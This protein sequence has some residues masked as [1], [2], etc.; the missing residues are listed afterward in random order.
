[1]P[2]EIF[3][4][5]ALA[6]EWSGDYDVQEVP[7]DEKPLYQVGIFILLLATVVLG[8]I[9]FLNWSNG[10]FYVDRAE[11]NLGKYERVAAARG[12]IT[13]RYGTV[14]AENKAVFSGYL[15][16]REFLRNEDIQNPT[17]KGMREVLGIS[18][19]DAWNLIRSKNLEKSIEPLIL[20]VDLSQRE[21][22]ALKE[23]DL[24]T[25]LV[26]E[27]FR[28]DYPDGRMFS[29]VLGYIGLPT[30]KDLE[31][32]PELSGEDFI[33]KAGVEAYYEDDLR[34]I[35]GLK[36]KLRDARGQELDE[37]ERSAPESGKTLQ[38]T[39]DADLQRYFYDR[40]S[41]AL[42]ALDRTGGIGMAMNPKTGEVL[43][44][45]NFPVYDNNIFT[46]SGFGEERLSLLRDTTRPLFDRA[47]SGVYSPGSTIKPLVGVAALAERIIEPERTIFSPGYLDIP[48]P[49]Q[50]DKPTRFVDWRFQGEVDLGAALAQSSNVY[51]YEV[52]GGASGIAG[53]GITR[54]RQWW[55]KFGL[56]EPTGIDMPGE[57]TGFLPSPE[58]KE[59]RFGRPWLLGDT[60]NV[61]IGQG[62]LQVTPIALLNY[63][64][65]IANGGVFHRPVVNGSAER[66]ILRDLSRYSYEIKEVQKG[67][68]QAVE[69]KM[70]TAHTMNDLPFRVGGK[71]G[72]A[73]I[74]NNAN[75]NA[76]FVG[77]APYE[78]PEIAILV[79]V[80]DAKQGSLNAVP[81]AKDVL[82][83]Y[84]GHR[85]AH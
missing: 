65:A 61:S 51:F 71:T 73:Q 58:W 78:N 81:I 30:A 16:I 85:I 22:V 59:R 68:L 20:K 72:S 2:K 33:G 13:D 46:L 83:W 66:K 17:L 36:V 38:L 60:Y 62:D 28:R 35:P 12:V 15:D 67:M 31:K 42:T 29:S 43:A 70:G 27:G 24:P 56:E 52:G 79:M 53:L 49:Y 44:L 14:L 3:F 84:H 39:L 45:V 1:M 26:R 18:A 40:M 69:A 8:R 7:L 32:R 57:A 77:Y 19:E 10:A 41:A 34:G 6:D 50:P 5:E 74:N 54:L 76:F 63:I 80:E 11:A 75:E 37:H 82:N 64:S 47:I 55:Q 48:N 25:L 4:E 9:F 23:L 21:L